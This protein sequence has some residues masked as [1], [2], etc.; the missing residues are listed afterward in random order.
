MDFIFFFVLSNHIKHMR[1]SRALKQKKK[2]ADS[3]RREVLQA[4]HSTSA[5]V[6]NFVAA[7]VDKRRQ[8]SASRFELR[9]SQNS[10][11]IFF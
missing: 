6:F 1:T 2:I 4:K 8:K 11:I 10:R 9:S 3:T 7:S 5:T